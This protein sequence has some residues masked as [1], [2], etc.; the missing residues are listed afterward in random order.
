MVQD[1]KLFF[2]LLAIGLAVDFVWIAVVA[3]KFYLK[4]LEGVARLGSNGGFDVIIWAAVA[5]YVLITLGITYFVLPKISPESSILVSIGWGFLFG[6]IV[7][8]VYDF[9]NYATLASWTPIMCAVDILWGGFLC[10]L[11]TSIGKYLR[12]VAF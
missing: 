10:G 7:Y 8:G 11:L 9:T 1:I 4:Q 2:S 6:V 12:D 5:V 3:N